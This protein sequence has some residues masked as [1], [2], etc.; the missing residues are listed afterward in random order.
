ML[1]NKSIRSSAPLGAFV[2]G[3]TAVVAA[4][5]AAPA[6]GPR[7]RRRVRTRV[8]CPADCPAGYSKLVRT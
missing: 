2:L 6:A 5:S 7:A 3:L 4:A 1:R 8:G